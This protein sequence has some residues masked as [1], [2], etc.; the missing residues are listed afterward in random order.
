MSE[1]YQRHVLSGPLVVHASGDPGRTGFLPPGTSLRYVR[2]FPEG[3]D[4]YRLDLNVER[5][6]LDLVD[7]DP[8]DLV[9]PLV[10]LPALDGP[11]PGADP[12]E[13]RGLLD[14]LGVTRADLDAVRKTYE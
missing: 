2:T 5:F 13:L 9:D 14:A 11:R 6:P 3:F 4:R 12:A 10:S 7:A 8:P 1:P